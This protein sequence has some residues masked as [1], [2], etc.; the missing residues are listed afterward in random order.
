ML[1][2]QPNPAPIEA[3]AEA[4]I[5]PHE[6]IHG[7]KSTETLK[8]AHFS[9]LDIAIYLLRQKK[10]IAFH[11]ILISSMAIGISYLIPKK[12][13]STTLFMPPKPESVSLPGF[14]AN[15][16]LNLGGDLEFSP[17]QISIMLNSR[18]ILD[19]IIRKHDLVRV[20][21]TEKQPN[22]FEQALKILRKNMSLS[23]ELDAGLTQSSVIAYSLS[24]IDKDKKR[25][26]DIANDLV[27]LLN[28]NIERF[29]NRQEAY[30]LEFVKERLD[31]VQGEKSHL[32]ARLAAFQKTHK[33][34]SPDMKDQVSATISAIAELKKQR[35]AAEIDKNMLL[36]NHEEASQE[37]KI[38]ERRISQL[39]QKMNQLETSKKDDI[40]PS[41]HKSVDLG[42]DYLRMMKDFEILSRVE[43]FLRQQFEEA[44]IKNAKRPPVVRIIDR[45]TPPQ[46]K[47]SPK[48]LYIV[49]A[50]AGS[51]MFLFLFSLLAK[52]GIDRASGNT[53]EKIDQFK[54]AIKF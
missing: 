19:S 33:V 35:L 39:D 38:L 41:L 42:Y 18:T 44:R 30:T 36:M 25:A 3:K 11:F 8:E 49:I 52:I 13:K 14:A 23:T 20:Y 16:G 7:L 43:V 10:R 40:L 5:K 37:I 31:S 48:K 2:N 34:Y 27:N 24:V 15:F 26:A 12:Y 22:Y 21:K 50:I 28:S 54:K 1:K 47:N 17:R 6:K 45:A 29:S 51:Y 46:W 9:V 53:K 4:D 32:E